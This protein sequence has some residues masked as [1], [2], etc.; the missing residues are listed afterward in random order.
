M[1]TTLPAKLMNLKDYGI[2][3]GNPADVVILDAKDPRHAVAEVRH[4]LAAFKNGRRTL[5]RPRAELHFPA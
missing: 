5:T 1:V 3:E 4:P 2:A